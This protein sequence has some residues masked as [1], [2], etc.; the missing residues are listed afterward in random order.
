MPPTNE[1]REYTYHETVQDINQYDDHSAT[2]N[3]CFNL[4]RFFIVNRIREEPNEEQ[5]F[6]E[7]YLKGANTK[8]HPRLVKYFL[9]RLGDVNYNQASSL[10][11]AI[12]HEDSGLVK[13]L[14]LQGSSLGFANPIVQ[15]DTFLFTIDNE[16]IKTL[17]L[18]LRY[19]HVVLREFNTLQYRIF[20]TNNKRL[21]KA[22]FEYDPEYVRDTRHVFISKL[23][24]IDKLDVLEY[25]LS[26]LKPY[27]EGN[28]LN[29]TLI[30]YF[31]RERPG[32]EPNKDYIEMLIKYGA[33][34]NVDN[35]KPLRDLILQGKYLYFNTTNEPSKNSF[36]VRDT[37]YEMI[38]YLV[39][40]GADVNMKDE[41]NIVHSDV[42]PLVIAVWFS[43]LKLVE[44]LLHLGADPNRYSGI[45][46]RQAIKAVH[47]NSDS[48]SRHDTYLDIVK[49]LIDYGAK[50]DPSSEIYNQVMSTND[51]QL[52]EIVLHYKKGD[53]EKDK[54]YY[55]IENN[56]IQT[57]LETLRKNVIINYRKLKKLHIPTQ[58]MLDILNTYLRSQDNALY[59]AVSSNNIN[60]VKKLLESGMTLD[61]NRLSQIVINNQQMLD[62]LNQHLRTQV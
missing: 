2:K 52:I 35:G 17:K 45:A 27:D 46:I 16:D 33:N 12:Q 32:F 49:L 47:D 15:R 56:D 23:Y 30:D 62:I 39:S 21:I 54:L 20:S 53:T 41:A 43:S 55:R 8:N 50:I 14:Y 36:G 40:K 48:V 59:T 6:N 3:G 13:Y 7:M 51:K 26:V 22:V 25:V 5:S 42:T 29:D 10:T 61:F 60:A 34:V 9:R 38:D 44:H 1:R 31:K 58:E 57:V 11:K 18:L 19:D 28:L 37:I 24:T 4:I